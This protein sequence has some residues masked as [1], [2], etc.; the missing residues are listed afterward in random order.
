MPYVSFTSNLVEEVLVAE[1]PDVVPDALDDVAL[2]VLKV[3]LLEKRLHVRTRLCE[4]SRR[5]HR[6]EVVFG[7]ERQETC[8]QVGD[9]AAS[10]V[11]G[12]ES[13]LLDER[14]L[15][16]S[17]ENVLAV[18][19]GEDDGAGHEAAVERHD[20]EVLPL[21]LER[22]G[23][24]RDVGRHDQGLF[25]VAGKPH[26]N[27][28]DR[29]EPPVQVEDAHHG[30]VV[31]LL[32]ALEPVEAPG[33]G[34]RVADVR[35]QRR[36]LDVGVVSVLVRDDVVG[37]VPR[38]PPV[39]LVTLHE[40][41]Y[42]AHGVVPGHHGG[43]G[44][45]LV[46]APANHCVVEVVVRHPPPVVQAEPHEE[47]GGEGLAVPQEVVPGD[48]GAEHQEDLDDLRL[49]LVD[50]PLEVLRYLGLRGEEVALLRRALGERL[51]P[52]VRAVGVVGLELLG[53]VAVAEDAQDLGAPGVLLDEACHVNALAVQDHL[54]LLAVVV[55]L[56][57]LAARGLAALFPPPPDVLVEEEHREHAQVDPVHDDAVGVRGAG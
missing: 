39:H 3:V 30:E 33:D 56:L 11:S 7:L 16:V 8:E 25:P 42:V 1:S 57:F 46:L 6:E 5:H 44:L 28:R 23:R 55:A 13:G 4:I 27:V 41:D 15:V 34:G 2:A 48:V 26:Q 24:P 29:L 31:V 36:R 12:G 47:R 22:V 53:R 45:V 54:V 51:E 18:V 21:A 14:E 17:V 37:V 20:E 38:P 43:S 10:D 50:H 52:P 32:P 40:A 19:G 35:E 9:V 49:E